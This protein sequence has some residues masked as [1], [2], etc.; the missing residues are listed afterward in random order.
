MIW[1]VS[2][3]EGF[4]TLNRNRKLIG[5]TLISVI[6]GKIIDLIE[7]FTDKTLYELIAVS[8]NSGKLRH[9]FESAQA[10]HFD[11]AWRVLNHMEYLNLEQPQSLIIVASL[12]IAA[13]LIAFYN[14]TGLAALIR[15][16]LIRNSYRSTQVV[17]YG[18]MYFKPA[19]T[20]KGS[21]Y[22]I[23]GFVVVMISPILFFLYQMMASPILAWTMITLCVLPLLVIYSSFLSLGMKFIIIEEE[24]CV[25]DIY[26]LTK[27]LMLDNRWEVG[28]CFLFMVL[29][30]VSSTI[31]AYYLMGSRMQFLI[32]YSLS[33]FILSYV[34][35]FLKITSFVLYLLIRDGQISSVHNGEVA[36]SE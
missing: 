36:N 31:A 13:F 25:R 29:M 28:A 14:D 26:R 4:T 10:G 15:D 12:L 22:L 6:L 16:L 34:T 5:I 8:V 3:K 21:F 2:I 20:F 9:A 19:F 17:A 24:Q 1:K 27:L 33:I 7:Q 35:V 18:R 11:E 23:A 32:S 30:T